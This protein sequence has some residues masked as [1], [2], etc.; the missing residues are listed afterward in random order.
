MK[1]GFIVQEDMGVLLNYFSAN[2]PNFISLRQSGLWKEMENI[3]KDRNS[4][5]ETFYLFGAFDILNLGISSNV[6]KLDEMQKIKSPQKIKGVIDYFIH[7]GL[8]ASVY[9]G[10]FEF[11]RAVAQ[12]PLVGIT[13]LKIRG[14]AWDILYEKITNINVLKQKIGELFTKVIDKTKKECLKLNSQ[15]YKALLL[16]SYNCEDAIII[17]FT[18]SFEFNKRLTTNIRT[19]ELKDFYPNLFSGN[20]KHIIAST[21]T[22]LGMRLGNRAIPNP[23][24]I[25]NNSFD[26]L[27]WL[28]FFEIRPGHLQ[29]AINRILSF[30]EREKLNIKVEPLVGRNDLIVYPVKS[31]HDINT[32]HR[33]HYKLIKH[34]SINKSFESSE[35]YIS[36]PKL[37]KVEST[38]E[39]CK[40]SLDA[41]GAIQ[42]LNNL[43]KLVEHKKSPLHNLEIESFLQIVRKLKYLLE[44]RYL[45]D[46]FITLFLVIRRSIQEYCNL[47]VIPS[48]ATLEILTGFI[49][50]CFATRYQGSPPV[51]ETAVYP[52]LGYYS[53][54]QKVLVLLDYLGNWILATF[55]IKL[56]LQKFYPKYIATINMNCPSATCVPIDS[57]GISFIF[58]PPRPLFHPEILLVTFFHELGH[59]VFKS[60]VGV[61]EEANNADD[62][63][64]EKLNI[65]E[66]V[67]A[68]FFSVK[69]L[70]NLQFDHYKAIMSSC[71]KSFNFKRGKRKNIFLK[72][73]KDQINDA[74]LLA[75]IIKDSNKY[76]NNKTIKRLSQTV[77]IKNL[78]ICEKLFEF[79]AYIANWEENEVI[80]GVRTFLSSE[81]KQKE[82]WNLWILLNSKRGEC[83]YNF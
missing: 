48:R 22:I 43:I 69:I 34:A 79:L 57:I 26:S 44:N 33:I 27:N 45:H 11:N 67:F 18:N 40:I 14:S 62:K 6:N 23:V 16:L 76:G 58:L 81:Q 75:D 32:F 31:N 52:T 71:L 12:N 51:G 17:I 8:I 50:L 42:E 4:T 78:L 35:T 74:K 83:Y 53:M 65:L 19:L 80:V 5:F 29:N 24:I 39:P 30:R 38:E 47:K 25:R 20:S 60:F 13:T 41:K 56:S 28:T 68:E 63:T 2:L 49:E 82:F 10:P 15:A 36:F 7:Y 37:R 59:V 73:K 61:L 64:K 3:C 70:S 66:E 72:Q 9:P 55:A 77:Q 54:G 46:S 21:H 1:D